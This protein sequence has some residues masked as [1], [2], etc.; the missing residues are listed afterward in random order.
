MST[1]QLTNTYNTDTRIQDLPSGDPRGT[2]MSDVRKGKVPAI[3]S[4]D[5]NMVQDILGFVAKTPDNL[6]YSF[7][8][9]AKVNVDDIGRLSEKAFRRFYKPT[10]T[11]IRL[12]AWLNPK[13]RGDGIKNL[14]ALDLDSFSYMEPILHDS[15]KIALKHLQPLFLGDEAYANRT[16]FNQNA[17][18][19]DG[20]SEDEGEQ[21][22]DSVAHKTL[23]AAKSLKDFA[24]KIQ[25]GNLS[26]AD[27]NKYNEILEKLHN[28]QTATRHYLE[29]MTIEIDK[30]L[31]KIDQVKARS[32]SE[33]LKQARLKA[34]REHFLRMQRQGLDMFKHIEK[35]RVCLHKLGTGDEMAANDFASKIYRIG[36]D[37][38][39]S[40]EKTRTN[41]QDLIQMAHARVHRKLPVKNDQGLITALRPAAVEEY[42][43]LK[44]GLDM[45]FTPDTPQTLGIIEPDDKKHNAESYFAKLIE[46]GLESAFDKDGNYL[47]PGNRGPKYG[48]DLAE[49]IVKLYALNKPEDAL[50][51]IRL[52]K[53][54][55]GKEN[56][57][58]FPSGFRDFVTRQMSA[59]YGIDSQAINSNPHAKK[60]MDR[61][62]EISSADDHSP[63]M[64]GP[65]DTAKQYFKRVKNYIYGRMYPGSDSFIAVPLHMDYIEKPLLLARSTVWAYITGGT[66]DDIANSGREVKEGRILEKQLDKYIKYN[67]WWRKET[68]EELE[69]NKDKEGNQK[70]KNI[71]KRVRSSY[72]RSPSWAKGTTRAAQMASMATAIFVAT[73]GAALPLYAL[74]PL[75][76][77]AGMSATN[78]SAKTLKNMWRIPFINKPIK[79]TAKW[80]AISAL[81]IGATMLAAPYLPAVAAWAGSLAAANPTTAMWVASP[82][83]AIG[84]IKLSTSLYKMV[85]GKGKVSDKKITFANLR[86]AQGISDDPLELKNENG[87]FQLKSVIEAPSEDNKIILNLDPS[88]VPETDLSQTFEPNAPTTA[89]Q[90]GAVNQPAASTEN[91]EA[92]MEMFA[93]KITQRDEEFLNRF[94]EFLKQ[95]NNAENSQATNNQPGSDNSGNTTTEQTDTDPNLQA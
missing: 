8:N 85:T 64:Y 63:L 76:A 72:K 10:V 21:S 25:Q 11:A 57:Q 3:L 49:F 61:I 6:W 46:K 58:L 80:A 13:L 17:N 93:E 26:A 73:G 54:A 88:T 44:L 67:W 78:Y 70:P 42:R 16:D 81:I 60:F 23:K 35:A 71:L 14:R 41:S 22:G 29:N 92:M 48:E 1:Q 89:A 40:T 2:L 56:Y 34:M 37:L 50:Y 9:P 7:Y 77:V 74:A 59:Y 45:L 82:F 20:S 55:E 86:E 51:A 31:E 38:E 30:A 39:L 15:D 83:I 27:Q 94:E 65:R 43:R 52:L 32:A 36:R 84:G 47:Q 79:F 53:M 4:T 91:I 66:I 19:G 69:K 95:Q 33:K 68:E 87:Q 18:T 12:T 62:Q 5:T 75:Y 90:T 28:Q 24:Q